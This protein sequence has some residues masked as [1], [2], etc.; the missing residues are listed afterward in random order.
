MVYINVYLLDSILSQHIG[1]DSA[2]NIKKKCN[3]CECIRNVTDNLESACSKKM[4]LK[5]D[6]WTITITLTFDSKEQKHYVTN[7][8]AYDKQLRAV[9]AR[10]QDDMDIIGAYSS[11]VFNNFKEIHFDVLVYYY[12]YRVFNDVLKEENPM[13]IGE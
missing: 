12:A 4:T 2:T 3:T 1:C 8:V 10:P 6:N 9:Y 5:L 13:F 7:F 11:D